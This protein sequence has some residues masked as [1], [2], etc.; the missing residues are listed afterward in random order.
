MKKLERLDKKER[1][2]GKIERLDKKKL[3]EVRQR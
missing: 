2:L 1:R 3:L